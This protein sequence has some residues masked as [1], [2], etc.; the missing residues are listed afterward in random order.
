MSSPSSELLS[1]RALLAR[2]LGASAGVV[3]ARLLAGPGGALASTL[4]VVPP[5][6]NETVAS[7][8]PSPE[9]V[10]LAVEKM[11]GFGPRLTGSRAHNRYIS[12]LQAQF[13]NSGCTMLAPDQHPLTLWQ[14]K[15]YGLEVLGATPQ[16]IPISSYYPRSGETSSKGVTGKLTYLGA[17]PPPSISA[18]QP[19]GIPAAVELFESGLNGWMSAAIAGAGASLQGAIA[20]VDLPLPLPLTT[21]IFAPMADYDFDPEEPAGGFTQDYKRLWIAGGGALEQLKSAGASGA[22][23]TFDASPE[24]MLGQYVPFSSEG[25]GLPAL[26]VDRETAGT[27]RTLAAGKPTVRLTLYATREAATS[28]S[29]VAVL[30]GDGSTDEVM[31][32]NTH[33]DGQNFVEENGGVAEVLLARYF[34]SLPKGKR[35]KRTLVF[36]AVTG[37]MA[38]NMPQ[39]KGFIE[40]HPDIIARTVAAVTIEHLGVS[41]WL[42]EVSSGYYEASPYEPGGAYCSTTEM[43]V[44]LIQSIP[45]HQIDNTAVLHGPVYFGIGGAFFEAG[46]PAIGYLTGPNYLVQIAA[47][48]CLDKLNDQLF[49]RQIGW[50]ADLLTRY[51]KM[52]ALELKTGEP[53]VLGA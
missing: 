31:V 45:E 3:G 42:D 22:I 20:L 24:A 29:I 32:V 26:N 10:R 16:R 43:V 2:A 34:H 52:S 33:T 4:P 14:A 11:V 15:R 30:P 41:K 12:W 27:L 44:P 46:I 5:G 17:V 40:D 38:P 51:D 53:S 48:G 50:F 8:L 23:F 36:S 47:N 18:E 37:H 6:S 9:K 21:A 7:L 35:L 19:G 39:T 13:A 25:P 49:A 1:R 28:P